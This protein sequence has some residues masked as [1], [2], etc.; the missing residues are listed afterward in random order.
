M[1]IFSSPELKAVVCLL[2]FYIFDFSRTTGPILTKLR[3]NHPWGEGI[4]I[5]QNEG[6]RP[7]LRG[8][9]SKTVKYTE[10]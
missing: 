2:D 6:Q 3:T 10:H 7:C 9:N 8:N 5:I 1:L 4:R